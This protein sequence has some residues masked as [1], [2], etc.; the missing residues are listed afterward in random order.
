MRNQTNLLGPV[1]S[2]GWGCRCTQHGNLKR[3][4]KGQGCN[5]WPGIRKGCP[6]SDLAS[7]MQSPDKSHGEQQFYSRP[8]L[9]IKEGEKEKAMAMCIYVWIDLHQPFEN[10]SLEFSICCI[11]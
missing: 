9:I 3:K 2:S 6:S 11:I 7:C 5:Q 10:V 1:P 4:W 8:D